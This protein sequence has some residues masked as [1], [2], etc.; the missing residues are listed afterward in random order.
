M[1]IAWYFSLCIVTILPND[2]SATFYRQCIEKHK[3]ISS[4]TLPPPNDSLSFTPV[5]ALSDILQQSDDYQNPGPDVYPAGY[6]D[7]PAGVESANR[8]RREMVTPAP[9]APPTPEPPPNCI[10]PASLVLNIGVI[11]T[12]YRI[13]YWSTQLLTWLLI[14]FLSSYVQSGEFTILSKAKT[15]VIDNAIYYGTYL[16]IFV[17]LLIYAA[18]STSFNLSFSNL[19]VVGI[20]AANTWGLFLLGKHYRLVNVR[21]LV[22]NHFVLVLLLG[23]GLVEIP[24]SFWHRSS[25]QHQIEW[26]YFNLAKITEEKHEAVEELE[27]VLGEAKKVSEAVRFGHP[28][29]KHVNTIIKKCPDEFQDELAR[30]QDDYRE[31]SDTNIPSQR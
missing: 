19:K 31:Y 15:A 12:L 5:A 4:T 21:L 11:P 6:G 7:Y 10:E 26:E 20:S 17:I 2:I 25:I 16:I 27:S 8:Y 29:R 1:L 30:E 22:I 28:C 13:V 9:T 24:R 14:P 3:E 23:Y 18:A